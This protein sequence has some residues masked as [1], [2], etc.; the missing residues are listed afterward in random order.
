[1]DIRAF[2]S[3]FTFFRMSFMF[4]VIPSNYL[5]MVY[6]VIFVVGKYVMKEIGICKIFSKCPL[7]K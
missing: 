6:V 3:S 5:M 7:F 2:F 4:I 1:M